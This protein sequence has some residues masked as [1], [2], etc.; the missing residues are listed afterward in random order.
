MRLSW[1]QSHN[2]AIA[3]PGAAF[4]APSSSRVSIPQWCDCCPPCSLLKV[5][6]NLVSIPQWCDCC[7]RK[8]ASPADKPQSF[9]SHNGAIAAIPKGKMNCLKFDVSIPQWCDCC[10][11]SACAKVKAQK[12]FNP[13][14]VR[15]L[16]CCN[17]KCQPRRLCFNPT[18]VR[19]LPRQNFGFWGQNEAK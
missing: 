9:Q 7:T 2:G 16:R 17:R 4:I 8:R 19:L 14:M 1:F 12:C 18:M 10:K 3:A 11:A 15:L 13:T 5:T 6:N